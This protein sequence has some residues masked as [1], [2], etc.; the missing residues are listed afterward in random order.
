M[1]ITSIQIHQLRHHPTGLLR[2]ITD[3]GR[4]G[5]CPGITPEVGRM[6]IDHGASVVVGANPVDRERLWQALAEI[7]RSQKI[8][9]RAYLDI[10]LWDLV[11]GAADMPLFRYINGFRQRCPACLR[12]SEDLGADAVVQEAKQAQED[13]F[14]GY[15]VTAHL[16]VAAQAVL[17]RQ[18]RGAVGDDFYLRLDGNQGYTVTEAIRIGRVLEEIDAFCFDRPRPDGD[19]V[20]AKAVA[21][22]IDTPVTVTAST[23]IE[24]A[25]PFAVEATDQLRT[26][27]PWGGGITD[28]LKIVR[29]AE[30]FGALCHLHGVG[31]ADG[32]AHAHVIGAVKNT[33]F[34]E[35]T[36]VGV[37]CASPIIRNPVRVDNGTVEM[38]SGPGLGIDLDLDALERETTEVMENS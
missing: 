34:F 35:A 10:A 31:A 25:Q 3:S 9:V 6:I 4:E 37:Q 12:G 1:E 30:A 8:A 7:D 26:G 17:L 28:A 23:P 29:C 15:I 19:L 2:L 27:T 38:P 21:D 18:I 5:L 11:A 33:P 14:A 16:E 32:F 13:G 36:G 20:G 22:A 24:A